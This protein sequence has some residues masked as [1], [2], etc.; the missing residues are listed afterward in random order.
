MENI[1]RIIAFIIDRVIAG[2]PSAKEEII[3]ADLVKFGFNLQEIDAAIGW[4]SI[5]A[6][7]QPIGRSSSVRILLPTEYG[8]FT[9]EALRELQ[10]L[11]FEGLLSMDAYEDILSLAQN[12]EREPITQNEL[13]DLI[14]S[15]HTREDIVDYPTGKMVSIH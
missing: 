11:Y 13:Y 8:C 10:C 12:L 6:T 14:S 15:I 5:P 1:K 4:M 7:G 2:G 3:R 9:D